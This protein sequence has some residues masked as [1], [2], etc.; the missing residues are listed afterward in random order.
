MRF[1]Q[2]PIEVVVKGITSG[3]IWLEPHD[4]ALS[5]KA[6]K[7]RDRSGKSGKDAKERRRELERLVRAADEAIKKSREL[8]ARR[9]H[10]PG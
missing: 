2:V 3:N 5:A 8:R 9:K 10:Q 4:R 7:S 6:C 1:E